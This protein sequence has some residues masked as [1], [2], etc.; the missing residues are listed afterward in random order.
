MPHPPPTPLRVL[1]TGGGVAALESV[2]ALRSLAGD[3]VSVE[4]LAPGA[5]FAHRPFSVRSPFTGSPAPLISFDRAH[6][7]HH[8]GAL[9]E[10][11]AARHEVHTTDGGHLP[12]DRL[13]IATGAQPVEAVHG[14]TMFRGPVSAGAV[15]AALQQAQHRVIFTLP[16]EASWTLPVYELALLAA[17]EQEGDGQSSWSSPPS[18][19]SISSVWWRPM[20]SRVCCTARASSSWATARP[21]QSS[22]T[23]C[24][25][26]T[27]NC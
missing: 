14:A 17:H 5:D 23:R 7:K 16:A 22:A 3:R 2:L 20:R 6:V 25:S 9:A 1:V 4:L 11:D 26:V 10:V 15:E 21:T 19:R 13:I 18:G 8:R 24:C 12:Y 27:A